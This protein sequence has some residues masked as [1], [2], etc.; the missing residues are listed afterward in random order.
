MALQGGIIGRTDDMIDV[1]GVNVD[2]SALDE[3]VLSS[4]D[5]AEYRV[6]VSRSKALPELNV[7]IETS[8]QC[9]DQAALA[10]KIQKALEATLGLTVPVQ[11][12][13]SGTLPRSEM[14]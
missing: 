10:G 4:G 13:P 9:R 14:K 8:G 7:T 5:V 12:A 11:V 2:P 3:I 6:E 1:R